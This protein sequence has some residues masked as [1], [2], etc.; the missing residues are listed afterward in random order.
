MNKVLAFSKYVFADVLW[1]TSVVFQH[2]ACFDLFET[3]AWYLYLLAVAFAIL[4]YVILLC[5]K[6]IKMHRQLFFF[7]LFIIFPFL[8][9]SIIQLC[10]VVIASNWI[11]L[12]VFSVIW[13]LIHCFILIRYRK[14]D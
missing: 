9:F 7:N 13:N 14:T 11:G 10:N 4:Q 3:N 2:I 12:S 6:K 5:L 8:L 1:L